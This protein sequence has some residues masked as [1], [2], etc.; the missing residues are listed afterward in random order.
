MKGVMDLSWIEYTYSIYGRVNT[1]IQ[2][3]LQLSPQRFCW[4]I[5]ARITEQMRMV[6][7]ARCRVVTVHRDFV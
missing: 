1:D 3:M 7:A 5:G 2:G 4:G 6:D